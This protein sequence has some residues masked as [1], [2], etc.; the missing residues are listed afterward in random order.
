[1]LK[2]RIC[3]YIL[4]F[5]IGFVGPII[6]FKVP[7]VIDS[8]SPSEEISSE[9]L[10]YKEKMEFLSSP[11]IASLDSIKAHELVCMCSQ[12]NYNDYIYYWII[13]DQSRYEDIPVEIHYAICRV[14]YKE[15][16]DSTI[17]FSPNAEM[18]QFAEI[19]NDMLQNN[20]IN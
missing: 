5:M 3:I 18:Q 8:L 15:L 6:V 20:K 19:V 7:E 13:K 12:Y 16:R 17:Y 10:S 11:S 1:M 4:S 2:G 9:S 14:L